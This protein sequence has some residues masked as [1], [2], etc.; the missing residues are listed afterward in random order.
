MKSQATSALSG[1]T[2]PSLLPFIPEASYHPSGIDA[3]ALQSVGPDF[4]PSMLIDIETN[5]PTELE[6][7]LGSV[8]DRARLN[9]TDTPRLDLLYTL[10]KVKQE[11]ALDAERQR[12]ERA[13]D[14]EMSPRS[15]SAYYAASPRTDK[16]P[17]KPVFTPAVEI[18]ERFEQAWPSLV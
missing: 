4:R 8:L 14:P 13:S 18:E 6:A 17:G 15:S 9:G 1:T 7:I 5:R 10:M 2:N 12:L 16:V 11:A 3:S